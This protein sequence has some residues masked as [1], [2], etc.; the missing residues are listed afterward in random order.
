MDVIPP[1]PSF[2][3]DEHRD[4]PMPF[5]PLDV[6]PSNLP[7]NNLAKQ[8]ESQVNGLEE[9]FVSSRSKSLGIFSGW[10]FPLLFALIVMNL[11]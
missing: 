4:E 10:T 1:D 9:N 2:P 7:S 6:L 3:L 11:G 8:E 5:T